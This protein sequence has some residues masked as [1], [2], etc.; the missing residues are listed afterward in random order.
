VKLDVDRVST[1]PDAPPEAGPDRALDPAP[2]DW[3]PP[4]AAAEGDGAVAE[5]VPQAA[6]NTITAHIITAP[7]IHRLRPFDTDAAFE[8]GRAGTVLRALVGSQSLMLAFLVL[9]Q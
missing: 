1:V 5:V 3:R 9:I 8:F 4:A 6:P 2:P 7:E